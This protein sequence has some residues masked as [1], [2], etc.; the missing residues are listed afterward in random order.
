MNIPPTNAF[1]FRGLLTTAS[2]LGLNPRPKADIRRVPPRF[3]AQFHS[4]QR[5]EILF[6]QFGGWM[7]GQAA[8][9]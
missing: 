4:I 3:S 2:D 5:A 9:T 7:P 8:N 6:A 1:D